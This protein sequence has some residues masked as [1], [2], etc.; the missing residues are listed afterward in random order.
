MIKIETEKW[1]LG[2][3][4]E[5]EAV[6]LDSDVNGTTLINISLDKSNYDV[7]IVYAHI[8]FDGITDFTKFREAIE[9][10]AIVEAFPNLELA[11]EFYDQI[12]NP[13]KL[14]EFVRGRMN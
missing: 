14:S 7:C 4:V 1:V 11:K 6:T 8:D 5:F 10:S 9:N 13:L 12:K 3:E 2:D